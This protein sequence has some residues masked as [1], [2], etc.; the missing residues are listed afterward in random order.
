M[1]NQVIKNVTVKLSNKM[2]RTG[3]VLKKHSPEIALYGG[4]AGCIGTVI[5]ACK[6]T[7]KADLV[8]SEHKER[9]DRIQE[10]VEIVNSDEMDDLSVTYDQKD[11][12][13]DKFI[14]YCKTARDFLKLYAPSIAL[15]TVSIGLILWSH[16]V[17]KKRYLG[18]VAAYN[19]LDNAFKTYRN[20][21][22]AEGGESLDRH[23]MFGTERSEEIREIVDENGKK[24]KEKETVETVGENS[25]Q[26]DYT[27]LWAPGETT[28]Y[29][30]NHNN[31]L[32]F[33]RAAE[34]NAN[35]IL[36]TRGHIFLNEVLD[37][38]GY[39]HT[40]VGAVT[41]WVKG[42]KDSCV[43]IGIWDYSNSLVK[44]FVD[45]RTNILPLS[46]NVDGVILDL[47]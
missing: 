32:M 42:N 10:A 47:I 21:V 39:Q 37:F 24:K 34:E 12:G 41:G 8:I 46:F 19:A 15:G 18:V 2:G 11:I 17:M 33:L 9:L 23:Y 38:L 36:N 44:A 28:A 1:K 7:T 27:R 14:C 30:A 5:L 40:D 25:E 13:R 6:A 35:A 20:R 45:G 16:G 4:I 31:S 29:M 43:D 3:L 22:I 26:S